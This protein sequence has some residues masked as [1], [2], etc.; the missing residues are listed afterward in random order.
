MYY[1]EANRYLFINGTEI[2]EFKAKDSEINAMPLWLGNLS[3]DFSVDNMKK[4]GF[5]GY[6]YQFS[7]DYDDIAVDDILDIHKYLRKKR[8]IIENVWIY[9]NN[10]FTAMTFF[11]CNAL[12]RVS[13]NNQECKI[14]PEI[15]NINSDEPSFYP[16]S[17]LVNKCN[18]RC[19]NINDP[20]TKLCVSRFVKNVNI[21]VFNLM[22]GTNETRQ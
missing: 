5:C 6:V 18:G 8:G 21:K 12:K 4:A 2:R 1:N 3:K 13:M 11:S 19:N 22:S 20:Y 16:Y 15:I 9:K 17:I 10:I 14:S 7:V